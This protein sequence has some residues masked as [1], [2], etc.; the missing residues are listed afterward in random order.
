MVAPHIGN[1]QD[2]K[3]PLNSMDWA[4]AVP[5]MNRLGGLDRLGGLTKTI[6]SFS[7]YID[8]KYFLHKN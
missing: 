1:I 4:T 3:N 5:G 7:S 2:V 8:E 6:L